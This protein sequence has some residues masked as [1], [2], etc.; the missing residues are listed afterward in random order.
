MSRVLSFVL[1]VLLTPSLLPAAEFNANFNSVADRLWIG[2]DFWANRLHDWQVSDG[3]VACIAEQP[4]PKMR[5][6]QLLTHRLADEP[7]SFEIT[8]KIGLLNNKVSNAF[9]NS[10]AG[11]LIGVGGRGQD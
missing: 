9:E 11:I 6:Q 10:I 3:R 2:P 8:V 7:G 1:G 5:T 4:R